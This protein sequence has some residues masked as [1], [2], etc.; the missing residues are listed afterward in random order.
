MQDDDDDDADGAIDDAAGHASITGD[1]VAYDLNLEEAAESL[2]AD[3]LRRLSDLHFDVT[4][5]C[6]IALIV[7]ARDNKLPLGHVVEVVMRTLA[8]EGHL[9]DEQLCNKIAHDTA[10]SF[11]AVWTC[12]HI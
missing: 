7:L 6:K 9:M 1:D 11:K 10:V 2:V 8:A 4:R 3:E 12:A 5:L